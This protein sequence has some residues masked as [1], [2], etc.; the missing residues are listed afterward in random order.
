MNVSAPI[1]RMSVLYQHKHASVCIMRPKSYCRLKSSLPLTVLI[2][3]V[4]RAVLAWLF[5]R[6]SLSAP[7]GTQDEKRKKEGTPRSLF[8]NFVLQI[9]PNTAVVCNLM[10]TL[11][12]EYTL[13]LV[14][15][16]LFV[17][18]C[19]AWENQQRQAGLFLYASQVFGE[20]LGAVNDNERFFPPH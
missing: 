10:G 8:I 6:P 15:L 18:H 11:P 16:D 19:A 20:F 13:F 4:C 3:Y 7:K 12:S 1:W 17:R 14:T 9:Q 2:L 5:Y